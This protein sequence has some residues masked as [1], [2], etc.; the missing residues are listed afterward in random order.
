MTKKLLYFLVSFCI[1]S[2][3]IAQ[4]M[5]NQTDD[6][7]DG[8]VQGWFESGTS[9]NPPINLPDAGPLGAGDNCL[10][11]NSDNSISDNFPGSR[12]VMRN[13]TQWA[14]DY[15]GQS[16]IAIKFDARAVGANLTFRVSMNGD[17]GSI[18]SSNGVAVNT[19]D[20][21]SPVVISIA[22]ADMETVV[23]N[24]GSGFD[25]AATLANCSEFRI[26][27]NPV[28]SYGG[29]PILATME[30]DNITASTSLGAEAI[31]LS[32]NFVI[33][34]NPGAFNMNISL[35]RIDEHSE[36][37]IYDILGKR[38]FFRD[39]SQLN[40]SIDVSQWNNGVYL[41]KVSDGNAVQTKR[42]IKQ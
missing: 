21:W 42:F 5:P 24:A 18:S 4:V 23:S 27:S 11:D 26:L 9:P 34:P 10:Q 33:S 7:Q 39:I 29:E 12:M 1:S 20:G 37:E 17:G 15:S 40:T 16:I 25:V 30:I 2:V 8:T 6:F 14:G 36:I 13:I 28:P 31:F 3:V 41:V 32:D 22:F 19:G 35:N 38:I